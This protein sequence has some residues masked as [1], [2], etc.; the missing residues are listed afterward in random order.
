M[1]IKVIFIKSIDIFGNFVNRF[2]LFV[3]GF[4]CYNKYALKKL[5]E[6]NTKDGE[7]RNVIYRKSYNLI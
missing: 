5:S 4:F 3:K 6:I 1:L 2:P 7:Q